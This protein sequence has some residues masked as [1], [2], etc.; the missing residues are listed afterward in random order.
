MCLKVVQHASMVLTKAE[1]SYSKPDREGLVII[2]AIIMFHRALFGRLGP[3]ISLILLPKRNSSIHSKTPSI[4]KKKH[5]RPQSPLHRP[6]F[7]R[8]E[9]LTAVDGYI[10]GICRTL[11]HR[12]IE[13]F[14]ALI[15]AGSECRPSLAT[16]CTGPASSI[17]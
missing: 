3:I 12:C 17:I 10:L 5:G 16:T 1:R 8:Q 2:F 11:Y 4:T 7:H 6:D 14:T 9:L 13:S 15:Q